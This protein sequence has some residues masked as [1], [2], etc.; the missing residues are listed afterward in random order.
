MEFGVWSLECKALLRSLEFGAWG[1]KFPARRAIVIVSS[2]LFEAILAPMF[3]HS[4]DVVS[5]SPG[6]Q[7]CGHP[8]AFLRFPWPVRH[9]RN[10]VD[11]IQLAPRRG[12][13]STGTDTSFAR[14]YQKMSLSNTPKHF[15]T[16]YIILRWVSHKLLRFSDRP[17]CGETLALKE[18]PRR[19]EL[20]LVGS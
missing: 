16:G 10:G 3:F 17:I 6:I 14:P 11:R 2:S 20:R 19:G 4:K 7:R 8:S 13:G 1:S 12:R 9:R 18:A 15:S 5:R